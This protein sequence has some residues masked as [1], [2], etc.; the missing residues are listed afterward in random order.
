MTHIH[1]RQDSDLHDENGQHLK[2]VYRSPRERMPDHPEHARVLGPVVRGR[3]VE[4]AHLA[5]ASAL[6][7]YAE[8]LAEHH[9]AHARVTPTENAS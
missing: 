1:G 7:R 8:H 6:A 9:L 3:D 4:R 2:P 5:Y